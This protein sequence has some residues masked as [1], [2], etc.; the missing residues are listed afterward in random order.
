MYWPA[1]AIGFK[2]ILA[3]DNLDK[4]EKAISFYRERY[5]KK[6][7]YESSV[8]NGIH[9]LL[10]RLTQKKYRLF[11]ATS[12]LQVI[13]K[14]ILEH[15]SISKY[16]EGIYGSELNGIRADKKS[17]IEYVMSIES[18]IPDETIMIGDRKHDIIGASLN[19]IES[20]GI[21]WGYGNI[22]E[23]VEAKASYICKNISQITIQR[24]FI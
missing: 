19:K 22:D 17:L 24:P 5:R 9:D 15:L 20:I 14:K 7:I 6:G 11:V 4:V 1:I 18:L 8:Y 12:K 3:T 13:A 10:I 21:L 16:F 2:E 23:L